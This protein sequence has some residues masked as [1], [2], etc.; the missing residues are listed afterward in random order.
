M[1]EDII[2]KTKHYYNNPHKNQYL[3]VT[4][5]SQCFYFIQKQDCF[6][7]SRIVELFQPICNDELQGKQCGQVCQYDKLVRSQLS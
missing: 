6:V 7:T 5:I 4:N 3:T 1:F 2:M